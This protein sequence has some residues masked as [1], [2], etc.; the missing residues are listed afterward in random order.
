M[1]KRALDIDYWKKGENNKP[2]TSWQNKTSVM[3]LKK[4]KNNNL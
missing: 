2:S 1:T 3:D 4:Y